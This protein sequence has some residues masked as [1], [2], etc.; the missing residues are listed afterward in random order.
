MLID[1]TSQVLFSITGL[2]LT[3]LVLLR[4]RS[5]RAAK[6]LRAAKLLRDSAH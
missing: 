3:G 2:L 1:F 5:L 4:A 6:T